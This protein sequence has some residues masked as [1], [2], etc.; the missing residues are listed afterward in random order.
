MASEFILADFDVPPYETHRLWLSSLN[1]NVSATCDHLAYNGLLYFAKFTGNGQL[2]C[3][4]S[5]DSV[6][7]WPT[8]AA[9]SLAEVSC[10]ERVETVRYDSSRK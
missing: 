1:L 8:T 2:Y 3:N 7:C 6:T 5:W 4:S 10:P 9:G